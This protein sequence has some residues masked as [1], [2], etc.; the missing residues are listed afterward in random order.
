MLCYYK[1]KDWSWEDAQN[2][3]LINL[4]AIFL[5]AVNAVCFVVP[6]A[7]KLCVFQLKQ[8]SFVLSFYKA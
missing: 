5:K 6:V 8:Y 1:L 4:G 7:R 3:L 2:F